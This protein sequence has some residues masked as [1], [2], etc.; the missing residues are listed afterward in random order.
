MTA[1][2][3]SLPEKHATLA[4]SF[5]IPRDQIKVVSSISDLREIARYLGAKKKHS[6]S[7][8][9]VC[10][11]PESGDSFLDPQIVIRWPVPDCV[12]KQTYDRVNGL[13]PEGSLNYI[14]TSKP[15]WLLAF[16]LMHEIAHYKLNHPAGGE[17]C[18]KERE[19]DEWAH[20]RLMERYADFA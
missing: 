1:N 17:L 3:R 12:H 2:H 9:A 18:A 20:R 6:E 15:D 14:D 8:W 10:I 13:F 11:R 4:E 5:G 16:L 7:T 19:A